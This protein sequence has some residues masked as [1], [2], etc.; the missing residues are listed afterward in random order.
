MS[1]VL[2]VDLAAVLD[3]SKVGADATRQLEKTWKDAKSQPEEKQ[4]Q[5]LAKLEKKRDALRAA[6]LSRVKPIVAELA[7]KKGAL[8]VLEKGA[9]LYSQGEDL[10]AQVIAKL[11]AGGP[12]KA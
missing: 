5:L 4:R 2:V 12:L 6:L 10:T 8:A 11:D 9:V 3:T 1:T 7:K